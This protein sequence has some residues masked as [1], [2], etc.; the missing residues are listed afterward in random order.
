MKTVS[1]ILIA[2]LSLLLSSAKAQEIIDKEKS[3]ENI[4]EDII[5]FDTDTNDYDK[6]VEHFSSLINN[7]IHINTASKED[8]Q[9]LY[10]LSNKQ[11]NNILR[12]RDKYGQFFT[13]YELIAIEGLDKNTLKKIQ[14]FLSFEVKKEDIYKR[15]RQIFIS[16]FQSVLEN[17][18]AYKASSTNPYAGNKSRLYARY[19]FTSSQEKIKIGFTAEK[20][21]GEAFFAKNNKQGFDFYSAHLQ[22]KTK[23]F[24]K[25]INIGDYKLNLG[26]GLVMWSGMSMSKSSNNYMHAK[27]RQG[28]AAYT[29]SNENSFLRGVSINFK[30]IK[31]IDIISFISQNKKDSRLYSTDSLVYSSAL[32]QGGLHR[33]KSEI[34]KKHNLKE[35]IW[36][37]NIVFTHKKLKV[38]ARYINYSY[39]PEIINDSK[40]Y[41]KFYFSGQNNYNYSINYQTIYKS[42]SFYGEIASSK[43][44]STSILQ[45]ISIDASSKI[46][47]ELIYR[48]YSVN[49]HAD[50]A[51][52][53]ADKANNNEE[54]IYMGFLIFPIRK[55]KIYS[56][57]DLFKHKWLK[58]RVNSPSS[59]YDFFTQINY[60]LNKSTEIYFKYR[61]KKSEENNNAQTINFPVEK[62]KHEGRINIKHKINKQWEIR[63]RIEFAKYKKENIKLNG[64]M[65]FQDI[66]F[67]S[68]KF[69]LAIR[70]RYAIFNSDSYL[71]RI[72]AY[73]S[74]LLY[75]FSIPAYYYKGNRIYLN[76]RYK[77][78]KHIKLYAKLSQTKYSNRENIGSGNTII[79]GNTKTEI[80]LQAIYKF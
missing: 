53:F 41:N 51:A 11:I 38:G 5:N 45:G 74:D 39:S 37:S 62:V 72:Y 42:I 70:L 75:T 65:M 79:L 58:Y 43:S 17:E 35:S 31:N 18:K 23:G 20:D 56:H 14:S 80:K 30:P 68:T 57:L 48:N 26:Q 73:E 55:V 49:Y 19:S 10:I 21:P 46:K 28:Q 29:S 78:N 40:L 1:Y 71:T 44:S 59:S 2:I 13:I 27:L 25:Q 76:I 32:S 61:I 63:N 64:Y 15:G 77:Y 52:A 54:G 24:V 9:K 47:L 8:F 6:L 33:T 69:P 4:I 22:L 66:I 34:D 50:F 3:V 60:N 12:H 36:G 16:R 7:P 67:N